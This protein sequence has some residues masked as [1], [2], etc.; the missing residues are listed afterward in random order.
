MFFSQICIY[1][2]FRSIFDCLISQTCISFV[3]F[4]WQTK[5]GYVTM[6]CQS[7]NSVSLFLSTSGQ[8]LLNR[9]HSFSLYWEVPA[10]SKI[11]H[12]EAFNSQSDSG[13][14]IHSEQQRKNPAL[15]LQPFKLWLTEPGKPPS[16]E[17]LSVNLPISQGWQRH[18]ARQNWGRQ[19][20]NVVNP[21]YMGK[22]CCQFKLTGWFL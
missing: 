18:K 17:L 19:I 7:Q 6:E 21:V 11:V 4:G 9:I 20:N 12:C 1:L 15:M 14:S 3:V 5:K 16:P 22:T 13:N 10:H 2:K 8:G